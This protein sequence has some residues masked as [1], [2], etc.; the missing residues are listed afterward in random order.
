MN[1]KI[2]LNTK[3]TIPLLG[4]GTWKLTGQEAYDAVL[5]ALKIGYRHI[6]TAAVYGNEEEVGRAIKDSEVPRSDLFITTKLWNDDHGQVNEAFQTS[7]KKL[8]LDYVD[9]Y[10]MHWPVETRL[11]SYKIM[12]EFYKDSRAKAIGVSNFTVRHL[13][14]LLTQTDITPAVNQVEFNPFLNQTDLLI[15]C[16]DNSIAIEA[17]SPLTHANKLNDEKLVA[18]AK[19]YN[20]SPAQILLRWAVQQQIIAIPKSSNPK[21][22]KENFEIFDFEIDEEDMT[23]M[24]SWNEDARFCWNPH[25]MI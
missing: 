3:A 22:I 4:F 14:E 13:E 16:R 23:S 9:L 25:E 19:K 20:K 11:K 12:E 1:E 7:L 17:Y 10:L 21:R 5:E 2:T 8:G 6:D 15:Y 24:S 18:L